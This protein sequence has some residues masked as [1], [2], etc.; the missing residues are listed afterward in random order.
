MCIVHGHS[1][2]IFQTTI[3]QAGGQSAGHGGPLLRRRRDQ[4]QPARYQFAD[5]RVVGNRS[6]QRLCIGKVDN[7]PASLNQDELVEFFIA[8]RVADDRGEGRDA[9]AGGKHPQVSSR[10]QRIQ[11]QRAGRLAP[12]PYRVARPDFL[13]VFGQ[14]P[15]RHLDGIE[16]QRV[17]PAGRGN[18][19]GPEHRPVTRKP[20]HHKFAR[21]EPQARRPRHAEAEQ[22]VGIMLDL[23]DCL[24]KAVVW[25]TGRLEGIDDICG[26]FRH[27]ICPDNPVLHLHQIVSIRMKSPQTD[28]LPTNEFEIRGRLSTRLSAKLSAGAMAQTMWLDQAQ[29]APRKEDQR[30]ARI[31]ARFASVPFLSRTGTPEPSPAS[32]PASGPVRTT[33]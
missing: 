19:I 3:G 9:R 7:L 10:K 13:E 5:K 16:F 4:F 24:G 11:N 31:S 12:H 26:E 14:W 33:P 6:C 8:F 15:T 2:R 20:D 29:T 27:G 28:C 18:G 22:P 1:R 23:G 21:P 32:G 30:A 25:R 17:V